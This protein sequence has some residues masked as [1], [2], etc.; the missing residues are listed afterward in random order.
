MKKLIYI[1]IIIFTIIFITSCNKNEHTISRDND[2][3]FILNKTYILKNVK[4]LETLKDLDIR[5]KKEYPFKKDTKLQFYK[6]EETNKEKVKHKTKIKENIYLRIL[7]L[8]PK[9]NLQD[10]SYRCFIFKKDNKLLFEA[11]IK[12]NYKLDNDKDYSSNFN[13]IFRDIKEKK[14]YLYLYEVQNE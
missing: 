5:D 2:A 8:E 6:T 11:Y 7:S 9:I 3:T 10:N 1:I 13:I 14:E 4:D 12:L